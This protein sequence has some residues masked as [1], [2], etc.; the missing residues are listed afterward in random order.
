[1]SLMI[2]DENLFSVCLFGEDIPL[3]PFRTARVPLRTVL[4]YFMYRRE[5]ITN[6][7]RTFVEFNT[8]IYVE[9][10]SLGYRAFRNRAQKRSFSPLVRR[11][12]DIY[13]VHFLRKIYRM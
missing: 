13:T 7:E 3:A 4:L 1:M 6:F 10:K 8:M 9:F 11:D 2:D 5:Q 12:S